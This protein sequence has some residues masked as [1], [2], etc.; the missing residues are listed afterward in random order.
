[1][2]FLIVYTL[3]GHGRVYSSLWMIIMSLGMP[4][5]NVIFYIF[6]FIYYY[7]CIILLLSYVLCIEKHNSILTNLV[8][9]LITFKK[10]IL[11]ILYV[12]FLKYQVIL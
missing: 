12:F 2:K 6:I 10:K 4:I 7:I 5:G 8:M 11:Q 3:H 9:I 1:M